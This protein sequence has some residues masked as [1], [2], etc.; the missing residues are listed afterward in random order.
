MS[1]IVIII[2]D[3]DSG[4]C[5]M[6]YKENYKISVIRESYHIYKLSG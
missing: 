1:D 5:A 3:R 6:F 4:N 2:R